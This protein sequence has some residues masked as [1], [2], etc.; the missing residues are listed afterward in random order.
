MQSQTSSF[1][2]KNHLLATALFEIDI[3]T[4]KLSV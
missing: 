4:S 2:E 3:S 1:A